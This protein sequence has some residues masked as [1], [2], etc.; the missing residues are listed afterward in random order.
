MIPGPKPPPIETKEIV[1][2]SETLEA[3]SIELSTPT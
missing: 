3:A 1:R 2:I